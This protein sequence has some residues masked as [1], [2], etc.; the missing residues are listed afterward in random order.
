MEMGRWMER[1]WDEFGVSR[2]VSRQNA[3]GMDMEK[4]R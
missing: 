2:W 3:R 1:H 4:D